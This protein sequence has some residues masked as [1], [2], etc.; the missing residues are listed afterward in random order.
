MKPLQPFV[1]FCRL[2]FLTVSLFAMYLIAG[3]ASGEKVKQD[4]A[5]VAAANNM[6]RRAAQA[7]AQ[8]NSAASANL[9]A[10]AVLVYESLALSE[11]L[12]RAR[13][14]EARARAEDGQIDQALELVNRVL[15]QMAANTPLISLDTQALAYGR[16]AALYMTL[17]M[18]S[19]PSGTNGSDPLQKALAALQNA[20][21]ICGGACTARIALLVLHARLELIQSNATA[22]LQSANAAVALSTPGKDTEHANA[23]RVRAQAQTLLGQHA[24]AVAD[25]SAALAMDQHSGSASRVLQDLEILASSHQALGDSAQALVFQRLAQSARLAAQ[26]L[27]RGAPSAQ[28]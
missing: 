13:L 16:A 17:L 19:A 20:Q 7:Y 8:G 10:S 11:P 23:L 5:V 15:T 22:A 28:N 26:A 2:F 3:C 21:T 12:A 25:A 27:Q 14:S 6:E 4:S 18:G 24:N 9:Y 1:G